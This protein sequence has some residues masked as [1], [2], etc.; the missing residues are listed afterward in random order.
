MPNNLTIY[1]P[2]VQLKAISLMPPIPQFLFNLFVEDGAAVAEDDAIWDVKRGN[3]QMAPFV[4]DT[5][6]GVVMDRGGYQT[7]RI[8]FPTLA[9]ERIVKKEDITGRAFGESVYGAETPEQRSKRLVAEDL[10]YLRETIA[11]RK[12]WMTAQLL[13]NGKLDIV[14]YINEGELTVADKLVDF[15]FENLYAPDKLW[16][17]PDADV[18]ESMS[19][20]YDI[21]EAGLG[22]SE[23]MVMAK[24]VH[25]AI[26]K[27]PSF[28]KKLD[29][30]NVDVGH[31]LISHRMP[32]VTFIGR[33]P[34]GQEMYSYSGTYTERV[35]GT[36][37]VK[38]FI[39]AGKVILGAP[40]MFKCQYG[41]VSNVDKDGSDGNFKTYIGREVPLRYAS[42]SSNTV[43][44][45]VT[46]R[47][48][49]MPK[50]VS[51]WCVATVL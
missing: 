23:V 17:D 43:R 46:S 26:F 20:M 34:D 25:N 33:T 13:L 3:L 21:V 37:Q 22:T 51:A 6:G 41:P 19:D 39:P 42:V 40:K 24:N 36:E 16:S 10:K 38:P 28:L 35:N 8:T 47:P 29:L 5:T 31:L 12:E 14:K 27:N 50:N 4:H 1:D 15:G 2:L 18:Q 44:Q 30:R 9:P 7:N 45:R 48:M 32:G 49:I 11:L